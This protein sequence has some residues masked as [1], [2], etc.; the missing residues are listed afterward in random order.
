MVLTQTG[1]TSAVADRAQLSPGD[2]NRA[3]SALEEI[4][5]EEL[6][7]VVGSRLSGLVQQL[8]G[9]KLAHGATTSRPPGDRKQIA[10]EAR[11]AT[12]SSSDRQRP[13]T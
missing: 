7:N 3:F 6:A 8:V 9:A 5:L 10:T 4:L 1:L 11:S 2:V 12:A 13:R